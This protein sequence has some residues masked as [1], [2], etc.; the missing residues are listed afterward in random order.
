L[1]DTLDEALLRIEGWLAQPP[2]HTEITTGNAD[3]SE[4]ARQYEEQR[5][6]IDR[7][8]SEALVKDNWPD[9][10]IHYLNH[11]FGNGM[12]AALEMGGPEFIEADLEWVEKL[13][14]NRQLDTGALTHYLVAYNRVICTWMGEISIPITHWIEAYLLK[15]NKVTHTIEH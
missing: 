15:R 9:P 3:Y 12:Y 11:F 14:S 4:L 13:L 6:Q 5:A 2:P 8:L 10:L 7:E 1:G